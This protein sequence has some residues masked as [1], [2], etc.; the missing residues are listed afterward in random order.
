[1]SRFFSSR[2]RGLKPYVPGMQPADPS[3]FT[4]LN[5]NESPFPPSEKALAYAAENARSANLYSDT[6]AKVLC[7]LYAKTVGV[8]V[9]E[10]I[11]GNGSDEILYFAFMAFCDD[12]RP[13]VFPDIT[14]GFYTVFASVTGT[15][16]VIVPLKY[17]LS[18]DI[19]DLLDKQGTLF[20]A[21]PNAPT[22]IALAPQEIEKLA[23]A[24]PDRIVVVDEAYVDFGAESCIPLTKKYNNILVVQTF[25]K[26]RSMAGSRLGFAIGNRELINDLKTLKY[27]TN[28]YNVNSY[29]QALGAGT[30]L[31]PDYTEECCKVIIQNREYTEK[32]LRGFGFVLTDS[33]ANFVFAKHPAVSGS[34]LLARLAERKILVRHFGAE[35]I[36]DHL[37]ITVGSRSQ[38]DKLF[39]ALADILKQQSPDGGGR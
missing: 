21:N 9:D 23:A 34:E 12:S 22:G 10:V 26:S 29:T 2:F 35:R 38:M 7:A 36:K 25:S 37:R 33:K 30:L 32:V 20:I 13:A 1:M 19:N 39:D 6:D 3:G 17:D 27:S 28:P 18:I 16:Q 5:T 24:D 31:D 14:Y 11:A 8:D 15:E 4:K